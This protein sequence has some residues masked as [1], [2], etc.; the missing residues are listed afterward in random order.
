MRVSEKTE[1]LQVL[2][3][4]VSG[5]L[6]VFDFNYDIGV[7]DY[8]HQQLHGRLTLDELHFLTYRFDL[9]FYIFDLSYN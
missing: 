1:E 8:V 2:L 3:N 4:D 9:S 6:K 7:T 5:N